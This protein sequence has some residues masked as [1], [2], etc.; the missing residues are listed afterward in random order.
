MDLQFGNRWSN[1]TMKTMLLVSTNLEIRLKTFTVDW[2][3]PLFTWSC[4]K[5]PIKFVG[6]PYLHALQELLL[7]GSLS[8]S[9]C[10][11]KSVES[12]A[13]QMGQTEC[14]VAK[15]HWPSLRGRFHYPLHS[16]SASEE[17]LRAIW[18]F[19][20]KSYP[21]CL[22]NSLPWAVN[23]QESMAPLFC[24]SKDMNLEGLIVG[25]WNCHGLHCRHL[26]DHW[27]GGGAGCKDRLVSRLTNLQ[28][29]LHLPEDAAYQMLGMCW[30]T[31]G[32]WW[33]LSFSR[34]ASDA[35][36][37]IG[38]WSLLLYMSCILCIDIIL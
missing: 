15:G 19:L 13:V 17:N 32:F 6:S 25:I 1:Q 16:L 18:S 27:Q 36:L 14:C 8:V 10:T 26:E 21:Q 11:A 31:V 23:L 37:N 20:C 2:L 28:G 24:R 3:V 33:R 4:L 29:P 30:H 9:G 35:W 5:G 7:K 12:V 38:T 34:E 22:V